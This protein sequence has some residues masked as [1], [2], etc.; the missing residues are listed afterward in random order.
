M[1]PRWLALKSLLLVVQRGRALDEALKLVLQD[2]ADID[3]RDRALCKALAYGVCRWYMALQNV[4]KNYLRKPIRKKDTDLEL[5]LILGLYQLVL[6]DIDNHAAVNESVKLTL[7][8]KKSWARGLVNAVLR[9]AIR[10]QVRVKSDFDETSYPDW[11]KHKVTQDWP[12]QVDSILVAGNQQAPMVLRADLRRI[13][14]P[15]CIA[16]L[17]SQGHAASA[18][19]FVDTA[20]VLDKPCNVNAIDG[21]KRGIFSVQ[22]AAPQLAAGLLDCQPGMRVLDACAAPG[23]KTAHLL[24]ATDKLELL[25]LDQDQ[26][27]LELVAE[28]LQRIGGEAK[29]QCGDAAY[30]E[31]W[32]DGRPFDRILADVPCSASGVIRR[33]PDIKLLRRPDDIAGMVA[34]QRKILTALWPLLKPGGVLLYSTCSMF[35]DENEQQ[36]DW[37]VQNTDNCSV[38]ALNSVQW[39]EDRLWGRQILP[40]SQNMDG[41]YYARLQKTG[42]SK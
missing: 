24:Q 27:R 33:H 21:F 17:L 19:E 31:D 29:L 38:L 30:P 28:N 42:I 3:D 36:I 14:M 5:I 4:L 10:D 2:K 32:F 20:V 7:W 40:G 39:G 37:F 9:G 8:Q 26:R 12:Q 35:K 34:R 11:I 16:S 41:F 1:N 13:S 22:D 15:D 25:A 18:H 23:G 6:M